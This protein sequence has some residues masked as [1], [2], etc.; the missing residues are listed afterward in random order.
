M[1]LIRYNH[2][3]NKY[4]LQQFNIIYELDEE[5]ASVD[6]FTHARNVG[7]LFSVDFITHARNVGSLYTSLFILALICIL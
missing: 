6:F 4:H 7:S 1:L 5:I 2:R 3:R